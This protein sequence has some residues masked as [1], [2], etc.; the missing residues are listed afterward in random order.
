MEV[1]E[2][3]LR[4]EVAVNEVLEYVSRSLLSVIGLFCRAL[5]APS[6][7]KEVLESVE[8]HGMLP[9]PPARC[10]LEHPAE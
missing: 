3:A 6:P 10:H 1:V 8:S 2:L 7:V 4:Q 5:L 9:L